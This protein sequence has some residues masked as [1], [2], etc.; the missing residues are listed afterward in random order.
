MNDDPEASQGAEGISPM[1]SR[2]A[3]KAQLERRC[4]AKTTEASQGAEGISPMP[5]RDA[6]K[7]RLE[8]RCYAKTLRAIQPIGELNSVSVPQFCESNE[9]DEDEDC[10]LPMNHKDVLNSPECEEWLDGT[11]EEK[12]SILK[13]KV[14]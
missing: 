9:G 6:R 8:R 11:E 7:A 5:S 12:R 2:N 1:P 4:Y 13:R 3:R 14:L 10:Q